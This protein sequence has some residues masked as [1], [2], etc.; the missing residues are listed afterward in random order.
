M[1]WGAAL[2]GMVG[3][4][5]PPLPALQVQTIQV[6]LAHVM[7]QNTGSHAACSPTCKPWLGVGAQVLDDKLAG[8][9]LGDE[10][11]IV[12][13]LLARHTHGACCPVDA[14]AEEARCGWCS[15]RRHAWPTCGHQ[16][17]GA[18]VGAALGGG[19]AR[20]LD[21]LS[22]CFLHIKHQPRRLGDGREEGRAPKQRVQLASTR[23]Y[24]AD[25]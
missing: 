9:A 6:L 16:A 10:Q 17:A 23:G 8:L 4:V 22:G 5:A 20:A 21:E 2:G 3:C 18:P 15:A 1:R 12:C 11:G 13:P 19:A 14:L 25:Q 7:V 24:R